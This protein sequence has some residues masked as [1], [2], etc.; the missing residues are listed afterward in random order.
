MVL[1]LHDGES[2]YNAVPS[3]HPGRTIDVGQRTRTPNADL[4]RALWARDQGCRFPACDRRRHIHA[5]HVQHWAH[6][7][8]TELDNLVLLC[9]QH[10][11]LL[12]EGGFALT[13]RRDHVQVIDPDGMPLPGVC[14]LGPAPPDAP[15]GTE[16]PADPTHGEAL[17]P[18][19]GGR[20][21][22]KWAV[23]VIAGNWEIQ[24][25]R[26]ARQWSYPDAA[27]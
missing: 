5:H 11:R 1:H 21:N 27:A 10:H 16:V 15:T 18:V 26:A 9:G 17:S 20:M 2:A 25:L 14:D 22:L 3:T 7:G 13:M 12:H 6:G 23:S 8:P 19:N 4:M 24:R